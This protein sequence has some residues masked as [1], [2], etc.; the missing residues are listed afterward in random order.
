[1]ERSK[2]EDAG[3]LTPAKDDNETARLLSAELCRSPSVSTIFILA[4]SGV[5]SKRQAGN[6]K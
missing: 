3:G 2:A 5:K 6:K 1:M 4:A